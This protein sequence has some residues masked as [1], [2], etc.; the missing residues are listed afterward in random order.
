[1]TASPTEPDDTPQVL[2]GTDVEIDAADLDVDE[3]P[4]TSD[5]DE[6]TG[7]GSFGGAGGPGG[8]G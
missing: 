3:K 1:M 5:P 6:M 8:A 2:E 4:A 7:D